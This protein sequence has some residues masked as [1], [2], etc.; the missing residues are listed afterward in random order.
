MV[1]EVITIHG[2]RGVMVDT[3]ED[4]TEVL[5]GADTTMDTIMGTTMGTTM[6][7]TETT[8]MVLITSAMADWITGTITD[9]QTHPVP[10]GEALKLQLTAIPG[11]GVV[12]QL[13]Q[14]KPQVHRAATQGLPI[15]HR[16]R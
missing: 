3:T 1:M 4:T 9:I 6:A 11:T 2:A 15:R 10:Q 16:G 12:P 14:A 13:H 8:I 5:T 7:I